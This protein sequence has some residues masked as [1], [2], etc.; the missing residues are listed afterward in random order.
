MIHVTLAETVTRDDLDDAAVSAGW[1][2]LN[3]V[4]KTAAFPAQVIWATADRRTMIH[5]IDDPSLA[6]IAVVL[7]GAGEEAAAAVI[8]E[9]LATRGATESA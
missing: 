7:Q 5:I 8:R 3:I 9:K 2:L 4:P 1:L 6:S